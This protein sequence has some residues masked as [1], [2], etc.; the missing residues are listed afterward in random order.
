MPGNGADDILDVRPTGAD[1][2]DDLDPMEPESAENCVLPD[3][4]VSPQR[5]DEFSGQPEAVHYLQVALASCRARRSAMGHVLFYGPPGLGK[6]TL[7]QIIANEMGVEAH[8]LMAPAISKAAELAMTLVRLKP[9]DILFLDEIHALD[10]RIGEMFYNAIER[11]RLEIPGSDEHGVPAVSID[12]APFTLIGATTRPGRLELPLRDRF[13][14]SVHL[15][16]YDVDGLSEIVARSANL[17]G[18]D[19]DAEACREVALRS[20]GTPRVANRL[21]RRVRDFALAGGEACVTRDCAIRTFDWLGVTADG[22]DRASLQYLT[23][24]SERFEGGPAG[25][26]SLSAAIGE[27]SDYLEEEIEPWLVLQGYVNRGRNGRV[28]T[29]KGQELVHEGCS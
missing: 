25:L 23:A 21:L 3:A 17:M 4:A 7:A 8:V 5:L 2:V 15:R 29:T 26:K 18:V 24:L 28:L 19:I 13:E 10:R 20:R 27:S 12:L 1:V 14:H 9:G 6:T 22:L 11:F 16:R